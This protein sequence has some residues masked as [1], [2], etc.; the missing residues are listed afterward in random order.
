[1]V[2][3]GKERAAPSGPPP[4]PAPEPETRETETSPSVANSATLE[5]G[6]SGPDPGDTE[7]LEQKLA[8]FW[9]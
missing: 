3:K 4:E 8:R 5:Q 7:T 2:T 9:A 1:M 6:G